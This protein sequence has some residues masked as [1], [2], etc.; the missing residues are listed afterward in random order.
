MSLE[1][2][3]RDTLAVIDSK[4]SAYDELLKERTAEHAKSVELRR[5][6]SSLEQN[7]QAANSAAASTKY[8]EQNLEQEINL[9]RRN[10]EWLETELKTKSTEYLKFR[11]DKS[12]RVAELQRS[13]E[14]YIADADTLRRSENALKGRL[15]EQEQKI[16]D[17][18]AEVQS[19]TEDRR[20]DAEAFRADL[21]AAGRLADLQKASAE[22]NKLRVQELTANL[23]EIRDEAAEEIGQIRAEVDLEHNEKLAA[24]Q[25]VAEL[26]ARVSEL[27]SELT[28]AQADAQAPHTP[29]RSIHA[30]GFS[31]PVR[32]G[33]PSGLFTP[34]STSRLKGNLSV[35]QMYSEYKKLEKELAT[36]R[37]NNASLQASV[38]DMLKDLEGSKP[39]IEELRVDHEKL[40]GEM[41]QM[42]AMMDEVRQ[43]KDNATRESRKLQGRTEGLIRESEILSQQIRDLSAQVKFLVMEAH[44][45][46]TG[47]QLSQS[48]VFELREASKQASEDLSAL[49]DTGQVIS[50]N[51]IVFKN[52]VELQGQ[53]VKIVSMLRQLGERLESREAQE[54]EVVREREH[55]ELEAL[56][57]KMGLYEDELKSTVAQA[58]AFVKERD[59]YRAMATRRNRTT[60]DQEDFARSM[61]AR[62]GGVPPGQNEGSLQPSVNGE[63]SEV[64]KA[65]KSLQQ[66]YD[67]YRQET[68][69]DNTAL[70]SQVNE[71]SLQ[72]SKIMS[73]GARIQSLLNAANQRSQMLQTNF[74]MLKSENVELQKRSYAAMENATKQEL[75]TQQTAEELVE[76]K[77]SI[78]LMRR[79]TANLKAEKDLWKSIERRLIEDNESLRNDRGR[80][81]QL[82]S[83]LQNMLNERE[84]S[85]TETR[86]RLQTRI[87]NL[88]TDLQSASRKLNDEIEDAKKSSLRREFEH[89]QSQKRIDDLMASLSAARE[90]MSSIKT[91]RDHLQAR[92]DEMTIELRSAEERLEVL[93][94]R[95][96]SQT[97]GHTEGEE[98]AL[99]QEQELRVEVSELRRDLDLKIG[100]VERANEDVETYK[101]ISQSAEERLEELSASYD[102]YRRE[103]DSE[104]AERDAKIKELN[105]RVEDILAELSET[106]NELAKL[107]DEH[108]ESDRKLEAQKVTFEAELELLRES[109][110]R[111]N[112][113]AKFQTQAVKAQQDIAIESQQNYENELLKHAE[114]AKTLQAVRGE[115]NQL[116][117]ELVDLKSQAESARTSLE[118]E[119]ES[120]LEQKSRYEGEITDLKQRREEVSQRNAALHAQ[121]EELT[122]QIASLRQDRADTQEAAEVTGNTTSG[123]DSLQEE[124]KHLRRDNEIIEVQYYLS[125]QEAKRLQQR[126]DYAQSQLDD[127][128]LKLEQQRRS[129]A[130][131]ERNAMNHN[132]LMETLNELNLY[133]E[134]NVT[135]RAETNHARTA[136]AE[137][138]QQI[139][140]LQSKIAPL[141]LRIEEVEGLLEIRDGELKLEK[142]NSEHWQQR[143]QNI[144]SKHDRVDPA[145]LESMKE[146]LSSLEG[147]RNEAVAARDVLQEQVTAHPEAI[148]AAKQELRSRLSEQFKGRSKELTGRIRDKQNEVDSAIAEKALVQN[149]LDEAKTEL[150]TLRGNSAKSPAGVNGV[151]EESIKSPGEATDDTA[152]QAK[153]SELQSKVSELEAILAAKVSEFRTREAELKEILNKR[154]TEV[155]KELAEEKDKALKQLEMSLNAEHQKEVDELRSSLASETNGTLTATPSEAPAATPATVDKISIQDLKPEDLTVSDT[156]AMWLIKNNP[157][158]N[159]ILKNNIRKAVDNA[160]TK[161]QEELAK[162]SAKTEGPDE[163]P[164]AAGAEGGGDFAAQKEQIVKDMQ[165]SFE[166]EKNALI[167]E[168]QNTLIN[169]KQNLILHHME[170]LES[171]K[172]EFSKESEEK[173]AE[174]VALAKRGNELKNNISAKNLLL[175]NTKLKVVE[176][177]SSETPDRPVSEVWEV[178]KVTKAPMQAP[179]P[180]A[181]Q[182]KSAPA[183]ALMPA[184]EKSATPSTTT[185]AS[186]P[187]APADAIA[188]TVTAPVTP[189]AP[190]TSAT[191]TATASM[192]QTSGIPQ[193]QQ[194]QASSQRGSGIPRGGPRGGR[195]RGGNVQTSN[196]PHAKPA[197]AGSPSRG[198]MNPAAR[199]FQP[200]GNKRAREETGDSN[201]AG[202]GNQGKRIRGGGQGQGS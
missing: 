91:D 140:E 195:G 99:S 161:F 51:L 197:G 201:I 143:Y 168:H 158:I 154:L 57:K 12:A 190:T 23:D 30:N 60:I 157:K 84:Q 21:E 77:A 175:A 96:T 188:A 156:Q 115:A 17:L 55:Q 95:T 130:D 22:T 75:K 88:E 196:F 180:P 134:S 44:I 38:D 36:E 41:S 9:L 198:G 124:I 160:N 82:N 164:A 165:A 162:I 103:T 68:G 116:R 125:T 199:Q 19:I 61:P 1:T 173:I 20:R 101:K 2:S 83:S 13:N 189:S 126:L 85:D 119:Q 151:T 48:E 163:R 192:N 43:E 37:R 102:D 78:D 15:E 114:A 133:R 184:A 121:L 100:E 64:L 135:L 169:E 7:L 145:E 193:L 81:D 177:A 58:Q 178:V 179:N 109:E 128:R 70:K 86:R 73:E 53:N 94:S 111:S 167:E 56:R 92:V 54:R 26:E 16:D 127:T 153:I 11:K 90:E 136:I 120:W 106:N 66:Q 122:K 105:Q 202:D 33:T 137:K 10:N 97:N 76:T 34:G 5:H 147:E 117:I 87:E 113:E 112:E 146:K 72:N 45:R 200:G 29:S 142:S 170:V 191:P 79:E 47:D 74:N 39:E 138:T 108:S 181:S 42:S 129:D 144:L 18:I 104:L 8:K 52:V 4:S 50:K 28:I 25:K 159:T 3:N 93:K 14:Q 107:R 80:L 150:E 69:T 139:D 63:E 35:T 171:Q 123:L 24:E 149:E 132:K 174:Q 176:T 118:Q 155:K 46:E 186:V 182:A 40:Q 62:A 166:A 110:G 71:L 172:L 6:I 67:T 131:S 183:P 59:M 89:G 32:P 141:Q 187:T 31:T 194:R 185:P 27:Q 148:E 65:L 49:S 152:S 98:P